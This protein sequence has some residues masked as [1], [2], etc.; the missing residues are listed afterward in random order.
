MCTDFWK[1]SCEMFTIAIAT[2]T[3]F[4]LNRW[5]VA[6]QCHHLL[7]VLQD[8]HHPPQPLPPRGAHLQVVNNHHHQVVGEEVRWTLGTRKRLVVLSISHNYECCDLVLCKV[9]WTII[10]KHFRFLLTLRFSVM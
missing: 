3:L 1:V 9:F 5:E 8:K 6:H 7:A 2:N 4:L 10:I